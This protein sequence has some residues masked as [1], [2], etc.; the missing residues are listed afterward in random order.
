VDALLVRGIEAEDSAAVVLTR[1]DRQYA[2][3]AA[4]AARP[5]NQEPGRGEISAFVARRAKLALERVAGRYPKL[6]RARSLSRW[7]LWVSWA[8]PLGA[9]AVGL[10]SDALDGERINIL[11]FPLLALIAWNIAIY[12]LIL[13]QLALRPLRRHRHGAHPLLHAIEWLV[14]PARAQLAGQPTL[15]RGVARYARDWA[16]AAG[17]LTRSRA[18]RTLHLGSAAFALG[19]LAGM[20]LRARYA[21]S[22]TAGWSGTWAGAEA[23]IAMVLK[24]ILGP[25]SLLTGIALPSIERVRALRGAGENAGDWLI[26]WAVT[27]ALFVIIPRLILAAVHGGRAV[28]LAQRLP[29]ADDFYLRS[30]VRNALGRGGTVRIAPYG[31]DLADDARERLTR[32]VQAALGEKTRTR[33]DPGIPYGG[34]DVWLAENGQGL[35]GADQLILLFNLGSTPEAENHG[36]L[37]A[38]VRERIGRG[39]TALAVFLDDSS[40]R[41]KLRGQA[42][43]E[44][45]IAER[46]DAWQAVLAPGGVAPVTVSLDAE[47]E[48]QAARGLEQAL[49]RSGS[50]A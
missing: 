25:A 23:E 12:L 47:D 48:A 40:F 39:A 20:L 41:R 43:A 21:A 46:L 35:E 18:S 9:F 1:E 38:G 3:A 49:M 31:F 44:R 8:V 14:R 34:E 28:M 11:A 6:E 15:E 26:L 36:A 27:A 24:I 45:R 33:L 22:Y 29:V 50:A 16:Q 37:V 32:L 42:S 17:P 30:L 5:M 7:P 19:V 10:A 4:L 13:V 2:T